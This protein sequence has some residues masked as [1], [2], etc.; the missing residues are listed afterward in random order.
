MSGGGLC[1]IS[2]CSSAARG[3]S[4]TTSSRVPMCPMRIAIGFFGSPRSTCA[5]NDLSL[6]VPRMRAAP[7]CHWL[8]IAYFFP[9]V[10]TPLD[11]DTAWKS[12]TVTLLYTTDAADEIQC[13]VFG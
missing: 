11:P 12:L 6:H 1:G 5:V 4:T 9:L 10:W 13:V 2:A 8:Q 7:M 3:D